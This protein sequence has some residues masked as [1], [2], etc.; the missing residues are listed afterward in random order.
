MLTV[1]VGGVLTELCVGAVVIVAKAD[2]VVDLF[3]RRREDFVVDDKPARVWGF[4][5]V[6]AGAATAA[7]LE[8]P[9]AGGE[10]ELRVS[11]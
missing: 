9:E 2:K 3:V 11:D 4:P 5:T 6:G 7:L 1:E 10:T 8:E